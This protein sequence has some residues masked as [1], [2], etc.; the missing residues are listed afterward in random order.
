MADKAGIHNRH[1]ASHNPHHNHPHTHPSAAGEGAVR[2]AA[3]G[4]EVPNPGAAEA[5]AG[6]IPAHWHLH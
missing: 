3:V 4:A 1:R 6:P 5:G 2:E